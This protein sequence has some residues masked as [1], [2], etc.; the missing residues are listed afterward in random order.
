MTEIM[1]ILSWD[2]REM[3]MEMEDE[4]GDEDGGIEQNIHVRLCTVVY[5][6]VVCRVCF[7]ILLLVVK[8]TCRLPTYSKDRITFLSFPVIYGVFQLQI[9]T[10]L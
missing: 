1:L 4:D 7:F 3:K 10:E 6:T 8:S 5:C 9:I 2:R